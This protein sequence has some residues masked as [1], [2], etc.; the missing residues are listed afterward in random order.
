[1]RRY[2]LRSVATTLPDYVCVVLYCT[3]LQHTIPNT[4]L[5]TFTVVKIPHLTK[6]LFYCKFG[7]QVVVNSDEGVGLLGITGHPSDTEI[8]R[9]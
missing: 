1:M 7:C 6:T 5:F 2:N 3:I 4:T 9:R 8:R